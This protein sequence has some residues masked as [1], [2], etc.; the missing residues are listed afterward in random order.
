[1]YLGGKHS[2]IPNR[3]Y[4]DGVVALVRGIYESRRAL[5]VSFR[6]AEL[7]DWLMFQQS[8]RDTLLGT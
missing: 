4:A 6:S 2:V 5:G 3:R 8:E 1:M 7:G